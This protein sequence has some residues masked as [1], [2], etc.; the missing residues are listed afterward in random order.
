MA[1]MA[2]ISAMMAIIIAIMAMHCHYCHFMAITIA[3]LWPIIIAI[4]AI[5]IAINGHYYLPL[6]FPYMAFLIAILAIYH[7][8]YDHLSFAIYGH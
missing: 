6:L 2:I 7:C 4:L 3:I 5:I 8:Q 1:I